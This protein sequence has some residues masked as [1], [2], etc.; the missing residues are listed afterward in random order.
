M[1]HRPL[2][3]WSQHMRHLCPVRPSPYLCLQSLVG[4][5]RDR[6]CTDWFR[7]ITRTPFKLF[8]SRAGVTNFP[9][10]RPGRIS[11]VR[12]RFLV[13][14]VELTMIHDN[15]DCSDNTWDRPL[16]S[17]RCSDNVWTSSLCS[18]RCSDNVRG[19]HFVVGQ[20]SNQRFGRLRAESSYDRGHFWSMTISWK[21]LPK[22]LDRVNSLVFLLFLVPDTWVESL[23]AFMNICFWPQREGSSRQKRG[24]I[25]PIVARDWTCM[26]IAAMYLVEQKRFRLNI[27]PFAQKLDLPRPS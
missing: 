2:C 1:Y 5:T 22:D 26:S 19:R 23:L 7:E 13:S 10:I 18:D 25:P 17:G 16:C 15:S 21:W 24:T 12:S 4:S 6:G 9:H 11:S 8:F 14:T 3:G 20:I 27:V